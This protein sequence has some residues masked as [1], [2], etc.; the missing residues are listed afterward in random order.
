M[1]YSQFCSER[2][3]PRLELPVGSGISSVVRF[4][5]ESGEF[6]SMESYGTDT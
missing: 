3:F 1:V 2:K 5:V 6:Q 4:R